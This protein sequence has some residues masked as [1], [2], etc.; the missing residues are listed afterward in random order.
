MS[1]NM[2]GGPPW[3]TSGK[4][5]TCQC[6][7]HGFNPWSGKIPHA[8]GQLN[9]SARTTEVH[10]PRARALQ[11]EKPLQWEAH[12]LQLESGPH[13]PQPEKARVQQQRPSAA[14]NQ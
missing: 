1:I 3:W 14:K 4:E 2:A 9:P 13:S 5:S 11:Q 6:R 10:T 8:L 7:E 12:S